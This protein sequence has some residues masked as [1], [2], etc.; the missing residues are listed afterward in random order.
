MRHMYCINS[1]EFADM[2]GYT[3][4]AEMSQPHVEQPEYPIPHE[5]QHFPEATRTHCV[6]VP[7]YNRFGCGFEGY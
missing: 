6:A 2:E 5:L 4:I 7:Q 1:H 3:R